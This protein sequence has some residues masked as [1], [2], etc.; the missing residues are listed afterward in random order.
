MPFGLLVRYSRAANSAVSG[1]IWPKLK[2]NQAFMH[3]LITCEYEEDLII[4]SQ[5][6]DSI[7]LHYKSMKNFQ[8]LKGS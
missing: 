8:T 6:D 4:N 3:V 7:F 1:G 2:L 5:C